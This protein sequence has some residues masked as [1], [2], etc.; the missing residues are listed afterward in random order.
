MFLHLARRVEL[1]VHCDDDKWS[2]ILDRP[3]VGTGFS[4]IFWFCRLRL[5]R[6]T[7]K[8]CWNLHS[9][10]SR[11]FSGFS[12]LLGPFYDYDSTFPSHCGYARCKMTTQEPVAHG[13]VLVLPVSKSEHL[14]VSQSSPTN[15]G[16]VVPTEVCV[17]CLCITVERIGLISWLAQA[18]GAFICR[19][20]PSLGASTCNCRIVEVWNSRMCFRIA[21]F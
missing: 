13:V 9:V 2:V 3:E 7:L 8:V 6:L 11:L 10:G 5:S 15:T 19:A 20:P 21:D 14:Q 18:A 1:E 17:C 12:D 4:V 16:A